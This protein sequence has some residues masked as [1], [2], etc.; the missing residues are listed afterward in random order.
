[1]KHHMILSIIALV[2]SIAC[3]S[4]TNWVK[5]KVGSELSVKFPN[6]PFVDTKPERRLTMFTTSKSNDNCSFTVVVRKQ[7]IKDYDRISKLSLS[8]QEKEIS[9]FLNKG[10]IQFIQDGDIVT[11]L[12]SFKTGNYRGKE[13]TYTLK[14]DNGKQSIIFEK[15]IIANN[16]LYIISF[17]TYQKGLCENDKDFFFNSITVSTEK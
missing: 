17:S 16:N 14:K 4:Q 8:E 10:V 3:T 15:F 2:T 11:P 13:I 5:T 6:K 1:M 12:K 7:V 9:S